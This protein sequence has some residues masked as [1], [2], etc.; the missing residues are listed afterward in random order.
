MR[1]QCMGLVNRFW[2]SSRH[3]FI[4]IGLIVC[5]GC[6]ATANDES[7]STE[8]TVSLK[9]TV[10]NVKEA[11]GTILIGVFDSEE[12]WKKREQAV[13]KKPKA[14]VS[15]VSVTFEL[16]PGEYAVTA[17]QDLDD[18][19]KFKRKGLL[20]LP[21]EPYAFSNDVRPRTRAPSWKQLKFKVDKDNTEQTITLK[22][23]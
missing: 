9:I 6:Y 3:K 13:G 11:K 16:K 18:N 2:S 23:P 17:F 1:H 14:A 15:E 8:E 7:E 19:G 21:G 20:R 5:V 4:W 12:G 10:S 22:H